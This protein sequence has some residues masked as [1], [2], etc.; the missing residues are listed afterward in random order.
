VHDDIIVF[1]VLIE[2]LDRNWWSDYRKTLEAEFAQ[3]EIMIR[4]S[5]VTQL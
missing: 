1:E 5:Q 2:D 3:D 4:A